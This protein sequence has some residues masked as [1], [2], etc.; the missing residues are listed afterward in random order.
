MSSKTAF[1]LPFCGAL[2]GSEKQE[3][4]KKKKK[5]NFHFATGKHRVSYFSLLVIFF[6]NFFWL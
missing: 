1:Y 3:M 5:P 4:K 2:E 6:F